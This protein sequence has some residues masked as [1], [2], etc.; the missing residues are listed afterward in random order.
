M[1]NCPSNDVH[2]ANCVS[3]MSCYLVGEKGGS[4]IFIC[5]IITVKDG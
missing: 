1:F 2:S 5:R 3:S 4:Q